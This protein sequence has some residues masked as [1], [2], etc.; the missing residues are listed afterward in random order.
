MGSMLRQTALLTQTGL[1]SLT[2]RRAAALVTVVSVTTVVGVL[3]SLLAIHEGTNIFQPESARADEAVVLS[4]GATSSIESAVSREDFAAIAEAPGVR[5]SA[6]GHPD[7]YAFT[8]VSVDALRR[9]GERGTVDLIGYTDGWQRVEGDVKVVAGRLYRPALHELMVSEPIRK[10]YRGFDIGDHITLRGTQW[11]VVG[12]FTSS[13]S[14]ADGALWA[15]AET[16]M[17]AFGRNAFTQVNVQ[18]ESPAEFKV[19]A[20]ALER[21]PAVAVEVETVGEQYEQSFGGLR[22]VLAFI[23]YFIGGVMAGGAAC[24]ALSSM[25]VSVD[26]RRREIATLR[27]V[28]FNSLPIVASVLIESALLVLPGAILGTLIAWLLFNGYAVSTRSLV[29]RL[30]VTPHL[31]VVSIW[32]ALAIGLIGGALPAL[33]AARLPVAA[34]LRAS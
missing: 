23:S 31:L 27:A 17:S 12:V 18:L 4:R 3:T 20:D 13:D 1:Y 22:H 24:A 11:T 26:S 14:L 10:M 6:D 34:A 30:S 25:Y 19:F 32:W 16:V 28:G 33:R 9:D 29:F 15:D 5:K 7:A 2:Q 8:V 21:N